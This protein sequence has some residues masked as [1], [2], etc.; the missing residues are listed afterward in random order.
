MLALPPPAVTGDGRRQRWG[1][2]PA[3]GVQRGAWFSG[4]WDQRSEGLKP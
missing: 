1:L 4:G 2:V 3:K